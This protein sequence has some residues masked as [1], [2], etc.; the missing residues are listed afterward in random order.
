[1]NS[2]PRTSLPPALGEG[3]YI[4]ASVACCATR[5]AHICA[6][7]KAAKAAHLAADLQEIRCQRAKFDDMEARLLVL[8]QGT[9]GHN[10]GE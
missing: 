1:M 3:T 8:M 10:M 7:E 6:H 9:A 5:E 2:T 4:T